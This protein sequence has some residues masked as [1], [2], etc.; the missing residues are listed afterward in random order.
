M[1][2]NV[3]TNSVLIKAQ[4]E[5]QVRGFSPN[6]LQTE[7]VLH[8]I[9]NLAAESLKEILRDFKDSL[10]FCSVESGR[11]NQF[12]DERLMESN[13]LPRCGS[14]LKEFLRSAIS[15]IIFCSKAN[16]T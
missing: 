6:T 3:Y 7:Q 15:Y 5:N 4:S 2:V 11:V 13:H 10:G 9:G 8:L 16:E 14:F 1:N 12:F